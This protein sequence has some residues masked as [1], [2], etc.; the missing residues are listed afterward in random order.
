MIS[1]LGEPSEPAKMLF[2]KGKCLSLSGSNSPPSSP[3]PRCYTT[4]APFSTSIMSSKHINKIA[5]SKMG[6]AGVPFRERRKVGDRTPNLVHCT[7]YP[8][9]LK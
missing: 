6:I 5:K 4:T 8:V 7:V 3:Q 1:R 9:A 2:G